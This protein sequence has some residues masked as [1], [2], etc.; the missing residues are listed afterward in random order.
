M[1]RVNQAIRLF[2]SFLKPLVFIPCALLSISVIADELKLPP[3]PPV[4][5]KLVT[6]DVYAYFDNFYVSL[7]IVSDSGVAISDPG[8]AERASRLNAA[9]KKLTDKPVRK[10]IYSH[11]HYDHSRG[12]EI[13]KTADTDF[14]SHKK[15]KPLLDNDALGQVIPPNITYDSDKFVTKLGNKTIE[16]RHFGPGD[17]QCMSIIYLPH[18]K[19]ILA[20]DIHL[21]GM[22]V[23]LDH[24]YSNES[25][26]VL[27]TL[28]RIHAELDYD[29]V[30]NGHLPASSPE[31]FD[32]DLAFQEILYA[33][34]LEGIKSG[35]SLAE[36]KSEV[37]IPAI[38]DWIYYSENLAAYVERMHYSILHGG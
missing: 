24:L 9:I 34:V 4:E 38:K 18:E 7:V 31:M 14:I 15:C 5:M 29:F 3:P 12:G 8:G 35:K 22:L 27:N 13:F 32:A 25:V 1:C 33:K 30:V 6:D 21:P 19:V 17:G 10:V 36:L 11:D 26:G 2:M 16:L 20:V 37:K 23:T 28:R